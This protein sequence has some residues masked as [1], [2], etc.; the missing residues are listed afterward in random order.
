MSQLILLVTILKTTQKIVSFEL[1]K[2]TEKYTVKLARAQL[3]ENVGNFTCSSQV[4]KPHMQFTY[5]TCSLP[6]KTGKFTCFDAAST[7]Q[8][9]HANCLQ[10]HVTLLEYN[11]YFTGNFIF[12]PQILLPRLW[13]SFSKSWNKTSIVFCCFSSEG[14]NKL[15]A[16]ILS[17]NRSLLLWETGFSNYQVNF[18]L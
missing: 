12:L 3:P 1:Q 14:R 9:I 11:G 4:K 18:P 6:V 7:S 16:E 5:V 8:K 15:P 2:Q 13:A 10:S 17:I